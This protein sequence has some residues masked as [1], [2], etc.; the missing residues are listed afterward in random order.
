MVHVPVTTGLILGRA[1]E[2]IPIIGIFEQTLFMAKNTSILLGAHFDEFIQAEVSSGRYGSA[3]EVIRAALRLLEEEEKQKKE[4][5]QAL[6]KGEKSGY[7]D[8]YDPAKHLTSIHAKH[9]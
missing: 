6:V 8:A 7:D 5:V 9:R 4:L 3:S 2:N 1:R